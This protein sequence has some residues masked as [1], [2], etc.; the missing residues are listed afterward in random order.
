MK[1]TWRQLE[2][3]V[4]MGEVFMVVLSIL[5]S[6]RDAC[7]SGTVNR[8]VATFLISANIIYNNA[9]S[10]LPKSN[11]NLLDKII[12]ALE[13]LFHT[14]CRWQEIGHLNYSPFCSISK[15][16]EGV[17]TDIWSLSI[18]SN[19]IRTGKVCLVILW[20]PTVPN[21]SNCLNRREEM[22]AAGFHWQCRN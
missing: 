3:V 1:F 5:K 15:N 12:P 8:F 10:T 11:K 18:T 21:H 20:L 6:P 16:T 19:T 17:V 22:H 13:V 4:H 2:A 14:L 7:V 9:L